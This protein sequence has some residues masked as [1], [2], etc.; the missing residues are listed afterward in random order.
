M[1]T[2]RQKEE[3]EEQFNYYSYLAELQK[4][5]GNH[6]EYERNLAKMWALKEVF[7]TFGYT[8]KCEKQEEKDGIKYYY[9]EFDKE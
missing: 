9:Y 3:L 8:I 4:Y 6:L 1:L 5:V 7:Y 2:K